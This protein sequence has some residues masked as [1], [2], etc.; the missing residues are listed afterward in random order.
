ML[1]IPAMLIFNGTNKLTCIHAQL[2]CRDQW[3][4]RINDTTI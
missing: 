4:E 2:W 1:L 3:Q